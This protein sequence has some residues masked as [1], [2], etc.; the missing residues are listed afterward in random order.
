[1]QRAEKLSEARDFLEIFRLDIVLAS[2]SLADGRGYALADAMRRQ[3]GT[4]IVGV[5]LS[6]SCLWLPVVERGVTVL[7]RR[8]FS[9]TMLEAELDRLLGVRLLEEK[10]PRNITARLSDGR[11]ASD[12]TMRPPIRDD[13]E[14]RVAPRR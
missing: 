9:P 5:P 12:R 13:G 3:S 7:G 4:L 2:E 14:Y 6:E 10:R 8:A 11:P 1:M